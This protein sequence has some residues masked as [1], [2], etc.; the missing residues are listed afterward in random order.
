MSN[1]QL[2][3]VGPPCPERAGQRVAAERRKAVALL[4][5]RAVAD[6]TH[7]RAAGAEAARRW[8]YASL[9]I[10]RELGDEPGVAGSLHSLGLVALDTGSLAE[11]ERLF[12][13]GLAIRRKVK[14]HVAVGFSLEHVAQTALE[15]GDANAA[16]EAI[17][18][19]QQVVSSIGWRPLPRVWNIYGDMRRQQG[20]YEE[21][22]QFYHRWLEAAHRARSLP[23]LMDSLVGLA[24]LAQQQ[25][26]DHR[27][28]QLAACALA[29]SACDD[30][31]RSRA[32]ATWQAAARGLA[33][34]RRATLE[35]WAK[36][37][38]LENVVEAELNGTLCAEE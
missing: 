7:S 1:F 34:E 26:Q 15:R 38:S 13:E 20:R 36:A 12:Q 33:P 21:A 30:M 16:E 27:A 9:D 4:A 6:Q 28:A 32:R 17:E 24:R 31:A 35:A 14:Q 11:A 37:A 22:R 2:N 3:L 5:V 19:W 10:S 25:S 18:D 23:V 29:H 8:H